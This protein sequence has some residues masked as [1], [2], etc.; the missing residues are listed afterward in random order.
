MLICSPVNDPEIIY[1]FVDIE[2]R[3]PYTFTF[4]K[5]C[6]V[7]DKV[8]TIEIEEEETDDDGEVISDEID[9]K[10]IPTNAYKYIQFRQPAEQLRFE[11][12]IKKYYNKE[13]T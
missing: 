7:F 1:L 6:P 11:K 2:D 12:I 3:V 9:V 8:I 13:I 10:V 5:Q 4:V